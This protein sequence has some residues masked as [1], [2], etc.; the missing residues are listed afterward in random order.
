MLAELGDDV[1][2][3][4]V[5]GKVIAGDTAR[6][7]AEQDRNSTP[8]ELPKTL[9]WAITKIDE[10]KAAHAKR[11]AAHA[12]PAK[13]TLEKPSTS[14]RMQRYALDLLDRGTTPVAYSATVDVRMKD[15]STRQYVIDA[16]DRRLTYYLKLL[17]LFTDVVVT[18]PLLPFM[19]A[20]TLE[21]IALISGAAAVVCGLR[22]DAPLTKALKTLAVRESGL[23]VVGEIDPLGQ[24]VGASALVSDLLAT[25]RLLEAPSVGELNAL[26]PAAVSASAAVAPPV[27]PQPAAA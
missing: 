13:D 22:G 25:I 9:R 6:R 16:T 5:D 23:G 7:I 18:T 1:A 14:S 2:E 3:I 26:C 10:L 24:I 8:A 20:L 27:P 17:T 4:R 11:K 12:E 21:P 15:G 19:T